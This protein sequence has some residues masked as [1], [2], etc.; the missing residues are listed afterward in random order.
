MLKPT[1]CRG[2]VPTKA[3][4][5][6]IAI[7]TAFVGMGLVAEAQAS[8]VVP[9][10]DPGFRCSHVEDQ[11]T[12]D[13]GSWTYN[14]T[15]YNDSVSYA[16]VSPTIR[17]WELPYFADAGIRDITSP[18]GYGGWFY[19]IA[20]VG[21]PNEATGWGGTAAWQ[22]AGDPWYQ[23]PNSPFTTVTQVLHW[24]TLEP[25]DMIDPLGSLGGFSFVADYGP[26]NAPYQASWVDLAVLTGDP[27]FPGGV[28]NSPTL[29]GNP[30]PEPGTLAMLGLGLAGLLARRKGKR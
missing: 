22:I 29:Q 21:V 12:S 19:E 26:T 7:V 10:C 27:A 13:S 3:P 8:A 20:T 18:A 9:S 28:P 23:G 30:V 5:S 15:V 14:F 1:N 16:G 17:D 11:V 2:S 6:T 24:Y 4:F 25:I